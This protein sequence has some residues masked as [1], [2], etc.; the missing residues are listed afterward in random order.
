MRFFNAGSAKT[1]DPLAREPTPTEAYV[2]A[3]FSEAIAFAGIEWDK[4]HTAH[5]QADPTWADRFTL[6][7]RMLA[8]LDSRVVPLLGVRFPA[9]AATGAEADEAT[10]T[11]GNALVICRLIVG[12]AIVAAGGGTRAEVRAALPD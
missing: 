3:E 2:L 5:R 12:E 8:F 7:Q 11:E 6:K 1:W 4:Y 9:I 10:A